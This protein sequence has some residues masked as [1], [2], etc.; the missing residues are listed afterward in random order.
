MQPNVVIQKYVIEKVIHFIAGFVQNL[1][2]LITLV[3]AVAKH[4]MF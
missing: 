2:G 4:I 1:E 3:I